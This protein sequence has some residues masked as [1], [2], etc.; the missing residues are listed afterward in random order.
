MTEGLQRGD[1]LPGRDTGD[2]DRRGYGVHRTLRDLRVRRPALRGGQGRKPL[3]GLLEARGVVPEQCEG[4]ALRRGLRE[5]GEVDG[6]PVG[7]H[8]CRSRTA[9]GTVDSFPD[10][11]HLALGVLLRECGVL[12]GT[13]L[14][15]PEFGTDPI[16]IVS[17]A[18]GVLGV[19]EGVPVHT[20]DAVVLADPGRF[21][22]GEVTVTDQGEIGGCGEKL[23]FRHCNLR[24]AWPMI[25]SSAAG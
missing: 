24:G 19:L 4:D 8:G 23:R 12:S 7:R 25:A 11:G 16:E 13:R 1:L 15:D 17:D 10:G 18:A 5:C 3:L 20:A 21:Q 22:S 14:T 6:R 2:V 9:L